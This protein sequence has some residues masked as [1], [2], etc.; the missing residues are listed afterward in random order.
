MTF[1]SAPQEP[2]EVVEDDTTDEARVLALLGTPRV[3]LH[4]GSKKTGKI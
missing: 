1:P 4:F 3:W 2:I